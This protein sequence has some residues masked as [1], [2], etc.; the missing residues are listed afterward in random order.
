MKNHFFMAYAGNKRKECDIIINNI[1]DIDKYET[2]IEPFCGS[3]ALS[4]N[5]SKIYPKKFKYILN[6]K[7]KFLIELYLIVKNNKLDELIQRLDLKI[8]DIDKVKYNIM[9]KEDTLDAWIIK[10]KIYS[11]RAGLFPTTRTFIKSFEYLKSCPIVEFI[12]SEIIT[13]KNEDGINIIEEHKN[14]KKA[15]IFLDPPYLMSCND[16]YANK[17]CNVYEYLSKNPIDKNK[18]Q[19]ILCLENVWI[20]KL[21]FHKHIKHEYEKQYE[22]NKRKTTHIIINNK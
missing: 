20:I 1:K 13:F 16:F 8:K 12:N 3:S 11:I 15:L 17:D 6:D 10:N 2:I 19:F 21:L 18:C 14:N 7:N 22:T 5:I 4:F 9:I